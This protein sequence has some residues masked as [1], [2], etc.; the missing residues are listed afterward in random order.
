MENQLIARG[1]CQQSL[2]SCP[3]FQS[4][5]QFQYA[6]AYFGKIRWGWV[7]DSD[8]VSYFAGAFPFGA[9]E[10]PVI[11]RGYLL[12]GIVEDLVIEIDFI[13]ACIFFIGQR[14]FFALLVVYVRFGPYLLHIKRVIAIDGKAFDNPESAIAVGIDKEELRVDAGGK[15]SAPGHFLDM[16]AVMRAV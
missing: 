1:N 7:F 10:V 15:G 5:I 8:L 14:P 13:D 2:G 9:I 6:L 16:L 3:L 11:K 4:A 12:C